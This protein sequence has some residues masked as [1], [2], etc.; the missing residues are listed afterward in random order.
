MGTNRPVVA[1][2]TGLTTS[3]FLLVLIQVL[4]SNCVIATAIS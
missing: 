4:A 1:A 3:E 2:T